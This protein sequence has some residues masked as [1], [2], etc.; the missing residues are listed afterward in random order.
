MKEFYANKLGFPVEFQTK[1]SFTVRVGETALS[2]VRDDG[3]VRPHYH[4]A[5]NIPENQIVEAKEWLLRQGCPLLNAAP[6]EFQGIDASED[7]AFFRGTNAHAIY[8]E[9]PSGNLVELIA[10]HSMKNCLLNWIFT[11]GIGFQV[12]LAGFALFVDSKQ[13]GTHANFEEVLD[14]I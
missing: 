11:L 3:A 2:F 13:R 9:D 1:D 7:I 12:F 4:Y 8:F 14:M 6:M 5:L 10:R